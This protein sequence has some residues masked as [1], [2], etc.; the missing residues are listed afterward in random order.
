MQINKDISVDN[1]IELIRRGAVEVIS[2]NELR[3]KL[4]TARDEDR[5]LR[6][7]LGLDPTAPDIHLG[8]AVVLRK[9]RLF[10]DLG[11]EVIIIIGD[12][13]AAIG[14]PS[15]KSKTRPQLSAE[16]IQANAETYS[17]QYCQILEPERTQVVFN[18]EWLDQMTFSDVIKLTARTTV[19]RVL[20][21]DDFVQRLES[22]TSVGVHEI[23]YPICQGY[24]S[25]VLKADIE[26]GGTDQKFNNLMGRDLQRADGQ[27]PQV[28]LLMPLL[29]GLDGTEKM[30]KSLGNYVGIHESPNDI[31]GK[32]MSIP[33]ELIFTYL[34]LTTDVPLG[35]IHE[36]QSAFNNGELHPKIA[37]QRLAREVVSIYHQNAAQSA[38]TYFERVH[39]NKELPDEIP[40]VTIS[41][42]NF[43]DGKI[44]IAHIIAESNFAQSSSEAI[45][46]VKQGAVKL[47]GER[48]TDDKATIEFQNEAVLQ[49]GKR[50]FARLILSST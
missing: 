12:F 23:L 39:K 24:D 41:P 18:S 36:M 40:E 33:D 26:M 25:V 1:Q 30:S 46:L 22:N 44:W 14:D 15:G 50:K 32:L 48:I 8:I 43:T 2:E 38:E 11:H 13:T 9:L 3:R 37:K 49:V 7:K 31:Y 45:R 4:I 10:Q 28:V 29:V 35:E 6:V 5:P 17:K 42:K 47:N 21:R 34:E 20:E 27:E 16:E 19:A